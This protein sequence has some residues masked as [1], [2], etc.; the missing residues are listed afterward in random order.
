M[1]SLDNPIWHSLMTRHAHLAIGDGLALR[2][3]PDVTPFIAVEE[4]SGR[5]ASQMLEIVQPGDRVGILAV[6]PERTADWDLVHGIEVHQYVWDLPAA[7]AWPEPEAIV[8]GE[9]HIE[10][11]LELTAQ[12]YPAYFRPGT[13]RLGHYVGILEDGVLCAMA[14]VRMAMDGYQELSAICT[15]PDHRGKGYATRLTRHLVHYVMSKGDVAFLHTES[16]NVAAQRVYERLGF[17]L[18]RVLPFDM[19]ERKGA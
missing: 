15:H 12:V 7:D 4:K 10:A 8:M 6:I 14:G 2:Y 16:D 17:T 3:P 19:L 13:A 9:A 11:M 5:A 18:R 1:T